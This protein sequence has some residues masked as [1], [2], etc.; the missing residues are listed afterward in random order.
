MRFNLVYLMYQVFARLDNYNMMIRLIKMKRGYVKSYVISK[1]L[2][3]KV[4]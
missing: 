3:L 1:V 4:N 2:W